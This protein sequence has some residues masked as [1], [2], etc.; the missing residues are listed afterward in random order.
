M[1]DCFY[2][3]VCMD[4][5]RPH[6]SPFHFQYLTAI[7]REVR[8]NCIA[9][10]EM[11]HNNHTLLT[12]ANPSASRVIINDTISKAEI[13]SLHLLSFPL[14]L[15]SPICH[16][17]TRPLL[18]T[19]LLSMRRNG[20]IL[21]STHSPSQSP[22][23]LDYFSGWCSGDRLKTFGTPAND[24]GD[25]RYESAVRCFARDLLIDGCR[26]WHIVP[27]TRLPDDRVF[28][29]NAVVSRVVSWPTAALPE[30]P[31]RPTFLSP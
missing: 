30:P 12:V 24:N 14:A 2:S 11:T 21:L 3:S 15:P 4:I 22:D 27:D 10:Y 1:F 17:L 6:Y 25:G 9:R 5:D 13:I 26:V 8:L 29:V 23:A 28:L 7:S 16:Q 19:V 18:P 31:N 20:G